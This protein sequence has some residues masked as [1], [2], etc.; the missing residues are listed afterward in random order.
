MGTFSPDDTGG[1]AVSTDELI[2]KMDWQDYAE[3]DVEKALP[4]DLRN[5]IGEASK[6]MKANAKAEGAPTDAINR[7]LA[8]LGKVAGGKYPYPKPAAKTDDK[9]AG[10]GKDTPAAKQ[11]KCPKCG[12]PLKDGK[13][14]ECDYKVAADTSGKDTPAQKNQEGLTVTITPEGGVEISGQPINKAGVKGF[15]SERAATFST[16]VK[17][18]M[19]MMAD[20]DPEVAKGIISELVGKA[21][22]G[23][24][25]WTSGTSALDAKSVKKAIEEA[26]AAALA[27]VAKENEELKKRL[28]TI[29]KSRDDSQSGGEDDTTKT[30]DVNK[31]K[32]GFWDGVPL[33]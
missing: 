1:G 17:A 8:F 21:L 33:R 26:V 18:L 23:D 32:K 7:V 25:K 20:I 28:E 2:E 13:C 10:D 15:T 3:Q 6:W 5:A 22:P 12:A 30:D 31:G 4:I 24:L 29:E 11:E 16:A 27:P 14:T 9:G 19:G